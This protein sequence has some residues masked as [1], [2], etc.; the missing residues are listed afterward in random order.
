MSARPHS[1]E[2][3]GTTQNISPTQSAFLKTMMSHKRTD[4]AKRQIKGWKRSEEH[5]V[6]TLRRNDKWTSCVSKDRQTMWHELRWW[7]SVVYR[8]KCLCE[9]VSVCKKKKEK[10]NQQWTNLCLWSVNVSIWRSFFFFLYFL[11]L[12]HNVKP[13]HEH[14]SALF[15]PWPHHLFC[16]VLVP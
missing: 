4:E 3:I 1:S 14:Y 16:P 12:V 9:S 13:T 2:G 7:M 15:F 6:H 5:K 10:R 11:M 8:Q